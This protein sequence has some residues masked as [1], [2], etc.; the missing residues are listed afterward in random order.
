MKPSIMAAV[1]PLQT[2]QAPWGSASAGKALPRGAQGYDWHANPEETATSMAE[3]SRPKKP[4][5][6]NQVEA[7][8]SFALLMRAR[9]GDSDARDVLF[10]RYLPR[11]Q[12][13]AHGRLP[14]WA[15]GAVDTG[16]VVQ[17]TLM[18]VFQKIGG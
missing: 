10:T 8:S 6:A 15:R 1:T 16:D 14:P 12:R 2:G 5:A 9:D 11:V 13:L 3:P 17:D 7:E 18:Q 4:D